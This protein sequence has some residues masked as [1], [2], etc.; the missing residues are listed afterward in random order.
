MLEYKAVTD[1]EVVRSL[2]ADGV[3]LLWRFLTAAVAECPWWVGT[4]DVVAGGD[5]DGSCSF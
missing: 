5:G 3:L 2:R 4:T 1:Q